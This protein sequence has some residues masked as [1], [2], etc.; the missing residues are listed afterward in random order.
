MLARGRLRSRA[1]QSLPEYAILLALVAS[2]LV[3]LL[4]AF[5][6]N[7]KTIFT[8]ANSSL[9][10]VASSITGG[11][12]GDGTGVSGSGGSGGDVS[13]AS[14]GVSGGGGAG[15]GSDVGGGGSTGGGGGGV[16]GDEPTPG[17]TPP[18]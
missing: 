14:G 13:A 2:G 7:I 5:G 9:G 4:L 11:S 17:V 6:T 12:G 3:I 8:A 10:F 16:G 18:Q 15:G 1:G